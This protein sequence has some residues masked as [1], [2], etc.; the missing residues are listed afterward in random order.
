[1]KNTN[2]EWATHIN[3]KATGRLLGAY[4]SAAK[5]CGCSLEDWISNRIAGLKWCF[6]CRTWKKARLFAIDPT[7]GGG[8]SSRCKPCVSH[9]SKASKYGMTNGELTKW[10]ASV[11]EK[12]SICSAT[13]LLNIDHDHTTGK[14]RGLLCPNCNSG[15]GKFKES[16]DLLY[17]AIEYLKRHK[18]G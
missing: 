15:I 13:N 9:A 17:A 18:N 5:K 10:M 16:P 12:C 7:R 4:K 6:Q 3:P 1:M 2:I 14:L 8:Q 11:P